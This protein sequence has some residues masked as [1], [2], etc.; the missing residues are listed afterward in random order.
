MR[1]TEMS[2]SKSDLTAPWAPDAQSH[3]SGLNGRVRAAEDAPLDSSGAPGGVPEVRGLLA[4]QAHRRDIAKANLERVKA[5]DAHRY[6]RAAASALVQARDTHVHSLNLEVIRLMEELANARRTIDEIRRSTSWRASAPLRWAGALLSPGRRNKPDSGPMQQVRDAPTAPTAPPATLETPDPAADDP[7]AV[8]GVEEGED[9]EPAFVEKPLAEEMHGPPYLEP[10]L[11]RRPL[12]RGTPS[13]IAPRVLIVAELSLPQCAKYRVW[14]KKAAFELLGY[15]CTVV[16]WA[17]PTVRSLMQT[18][19]LVIFYRVPG[20]PDSLKNMQEA[21]RLGIPCYWEVDDLN[22]D[23]DLYKTNRNLDTL[24]PSVKESVLAGVPLYRAALLACGNG[25]A[26]TPTIARV[27][28]EAGARSVAVVRNALDPETLAVAE[29]LRSNPKQPAPD[30]AVVIFYGSGS[31]THDIDFREAAKGIERVMDAR[32]HVTLRIAGELV[33]PKSFKRFGKRVE[34]LPPADF[35]TYLGHL[36]AADISIAPLEPSIFNDAKSNIKFL[37]AA[38]VE[39]PSVC[40]PGATFREIVVEGENGFLADGPDAWARALGLL[41]DDAT[42]R[43]RMGAAARAA[44]LAQ[45]SLESIA[46]SEAE[47]LVRDL[48]RIGRR[49][50]NVLSVNVYYSPQSFGG[51]TIVA[52]HVNRRL[53]QR[54]DTHVTV[55]TSMGAHR[56]DHDVVRYEADGMSVLAIKMPHFMDREQAYESGLM[57][58]AFADALAATRPDVVHFHSIQG[59]TASL[60]DSCI[61][62]GIPY[63]ITAHDAWWLCERQFMVRSN[64]KYCFQ[65]RI[66]HRVCATCVPDI[67]FTRRRSETLSRILNGAELLLTPSAFFRDLYVANGTP[68]AKVRVNRNGV[69]APKAKFVRQAGKRLRFGFVGGVGP[70]KGLDLVVA[71]FKDLK[72]TNYELSVV[73]NTLNIGFS[74]VN[75]E[76]WDLSG[77]VHKVP[78]YRQSE[79]D[80]FFGGLDVLLFPSQTKESFGLTVREALLRDV[81]VI[82]TDAGGAVEDIVPGEN[83]DIIPITSDHGPLRE[84]IRALLDNPDRLRAHVNPHKDRIA[85]YEQQADELHGY[86]LEAAASGRSPAPAGAPV[87]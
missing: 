73:D 47:H 39:V 19:A 66:D 79:L 10:A 63:V 21:R 16:P 20:W 38:V 57:A 1:G 72:H 68:A 14:Q 86:L 65:K 62:A 84:A 70:N 87:A 74:S 83:G 44:A 25:L 77:S 76:E 9:F 67:A 40:S 46:V 85:T 24:P 61:V 45:Y 80:A 42:L 13:P 12:P 28:T 55:F 5:Q 4:A 43:N 17:S 32:P 48:P 56:S 54:P 8:P 30:G 60:A 51:A 36:R 69:L 78:A 3:A 31:N 26:S 7:G 81:W 22:F 6:D 71:A 18:H 23:L 59:L 27:M 52:E 64:G 2:D 82:S 29:M 49:E 58:D 75:T 33:L 35:A 11:Y 34:R 15:E 50:L 53:H 37:E 41:C